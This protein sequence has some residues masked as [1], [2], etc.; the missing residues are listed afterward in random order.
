V[1]SG[2]RP[3]RGGAGVRRNL[4]PEK[5]S[6][7]MFSRFEGGRGVNIFKLG[8]PDFGFWAKKGVK[9]IKS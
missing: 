3:D 5:N 9:M 2:N 8:F 7:N 1:K 4:I 6:K